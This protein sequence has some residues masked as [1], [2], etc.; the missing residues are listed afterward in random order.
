MA[1][2]LILILDWR[3]LCVEYP[4]ELNDISGL[5]HD[6]AMEILQ[7]ASPEA[8]LAFEMKH[9]LVGHDIGM[10]SYMYDSRVF[11]SSQSFDIDFI[12]HHPLVGHNYGQGPRFSL[13]S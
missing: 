12:R 11:I 13:I 6:L 1:A 5:H 9:D 2:Y 8:L 4:S 10:L 7:H 3:C